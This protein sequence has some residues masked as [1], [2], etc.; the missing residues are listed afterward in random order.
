MTPV[1]AQ[2][3]GP[4]IGMAAALAGL[5]AALLLGLIGVWL[6]NYRTFGTNFVLGL[7]AFGAVL[8]VEN[9]IALFYFF[10]MQSLY[11]AD[12]GVQQVVMIT[13]GVQFVAVLL[14]T[15]VTMK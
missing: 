5:N 4:E 15:Y 1:P 13:R 9:G 12:P 11:A 6:R 14:L 7:L 8:L 3:M 2:P 10:S